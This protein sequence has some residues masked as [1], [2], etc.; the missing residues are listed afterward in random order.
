MHS[1]THTKGNTL[2]NNL[3]YCR[4]CK[5]T[6]TF[7]SQLSIH[8]KVH[9]GVKPY[10]CLGCAKSFSTKGNLKTHSITHTEKKT[11]KKNIKSCGQCNKTFKCNSHLI[12]HIRVHSGE[13]PYK[14][15]KC[16]K[17]F[18]YKGTLVAHKSV[19]TGEKPYQ[20]QECE[21][22]FRLKGTLESHT[23]CV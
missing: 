20:C 1:N 15:L 10:K 6:F 23:P 9:S 3:H 14:C 8:I 13:K 5:K 19:H 11:L 21:K 16:A 2:D 18:S 4:Q 12:I 17:S 22:S 7:N